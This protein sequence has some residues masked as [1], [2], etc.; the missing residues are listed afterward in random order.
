MQRGLIRR[1]CSRAFYGPPD[2]IA[3]HT[4]ARDRRAINFWLLVLWL[5]PG[6]AV[7]V[8]LRSALWFIG[9]MSIYAIWTGHLGAAS[10][11][12]PVEPE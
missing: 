12:T 10:A 3:V 8:I 7:W 1:G 11:E 5:G 9:F 6:L 4:T 2:W